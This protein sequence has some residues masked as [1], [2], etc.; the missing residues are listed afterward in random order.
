MV[1][2]LAHTCSWLMLLHPAPTVACNPR[3]WAPLL[4]LPLV[5]SGS[6]QVQ[7]E[8]WEDFRITGRV[9]GLNDGQQGPVLPLCV[10]L[11]CSGHCM[12]C[13]PGTGEGTPRAEGWPKLVQTYS[14]QEVGIVHGGMQYAYKVPSNLLF[15]SL[16]E[17]SQMSPSI[18][19]SCCWL[20][21]L[22]VC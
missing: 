4:Y 6:L 18:E 5:S 3:F 7:S 17:D 20:R 11:C 9:N 2:Q 12:V 1:K 21:A 15:L 10:F 14:A 19:V 22:M 8:L 13:K 16:W